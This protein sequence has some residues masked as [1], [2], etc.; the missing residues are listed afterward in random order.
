[1]TQADAKPS[2]PSEFTKIEHAQG[3]SY[4]AYGGL[5]GRPYVAGKCCETVLPRDSFGHSHQCTRKNGF[6]PAGLF[7]KAHDP[8]ARKAKDEAERAKREAEWEAEKLRNKMDALAFDIAE[9]C[10][11]VFAQQQP[12]EKLEQMTAAYKDLRDKVEKDGAS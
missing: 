5:N 4:G 12:F 10:V 2:W 7:C 9:M 11:K 6:G 3:Y 8:I 1:M